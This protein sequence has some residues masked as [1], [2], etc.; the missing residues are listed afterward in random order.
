MIKG[1]GGIPNS[2]AG[3]EFP[4]GVE[5]GKIHGDDTASVG[6]HVVPLP[7][8]LDLSH[9]VLMCWARRRPTN[10]QTPFELDH[11][12]LSSVSTVLSSVAASFLLF[13]KFRHLLQRIL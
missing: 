6:W 13:G 7:L 5:P 1:G 2:C 12:R 10:L 4:V 8:L 3:G 11:S 9:P